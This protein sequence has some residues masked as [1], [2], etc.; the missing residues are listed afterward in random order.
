MGVETMNLAMSADMGVF[1]GYT[2]V[3]K[4]LKDIAH[5]FPN[6]TSLSR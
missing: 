5:K 6:L 4:L 2:G 3:F 1:G